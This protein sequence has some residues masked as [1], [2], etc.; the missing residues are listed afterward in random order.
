MERLAELAASIESDPAEVGRQARLIASAARAAEDWAVLSRSQAVVGRAMRMLGEVDSAQSALGEAID[1]AKK[2]GDQELEADAH[3]ALSGALSMAGQWNDAF[4]HLEVAERLGSQELRDSAELQRAVVSWNVGRI[5]DALRLYAGVIPRLRRQSRSLDLA[6]ALA[7]HAG[8]QLSRG[9]V[10]D[11]IGDYEEAEELFRSVGK[12]F[13]A[14]QVHDNLG[15][16]VSHLGD[17][18][19]ALRLFDDA[20]DR[21][22]ELGHDA[23]VPLLARAQALLLGGLSADALTFSQQAARRLHAEGNR[24]AAAKA[25]LAAAEAARLEGDHT[26]ALDIAGRAQQWFAL[27]QSVGWERAAELEVMRSRHELGDLEDSAIDRLEGLAETLSS[28]GNVRGEIQARCLLTIAACERGQLDVAGKQA[29][30]AARATRSS[31]LLQTRL[32]SH[33]ATA[34]YRLASGD[35]I[36]ARRDLRRAFEALESTRQLRGAADAGASIVTQAH[37]IA[38]L[39]IHMATL[40]AQP[41]RALAWMERARAAGRVSRPALP[42]TADTAAGDFARLRV[43]AA[44]LRQAEIAGEPTGDLRRRHAEL[45]RAMRAEWLKS[46]HPDRLVSVRFNLSELKHVV[47]DAQ[48]VSIASAGSSFLAVIADRRRVRSCTL[49]ARA[50]LLDAAQGACG[51]LRGLAATGSAPTVAASRRRNFDA[52]VDVLDSL[53]LVPL[54]LDAQHIV[55]V[56]P[57]EL[58][59]IPWAALPSLRGRSFTLAPSVQWWIEAASSPVVPPTSVLAVAGPRV[60]EAEAEVRGVAAC[61]RRSTLLVGAD[62]SVVNVGGAMA[63]H[64][65]V[66]F[67]A[68]GRFRHDNPLW[69]TLELADG[70][71]S[72]YELERLGQIPS[73]VVLATCES[74]MGG[75]RSGAQLHGLAGTLLAMGAR[76]IV[77][78]IGALPDT[79]ATRQTMIDLHRDLV[80]GTNASKS[81]LSQRLGEFSLTSA[82]LVTLG[83][84]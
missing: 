10:A 30:L 46:G 71:L 29:A 27:D 68:H 80:N 70:P 59:A 58:H 74:G 37:A 3:I 44:D 48:V 2:G 12:E 47:G 45:E 31:Q 69:S 19:R 9:Q 20:S 14:V 35:R 5:D 33:H 55:L 78:A 11:A 15:C 51:A 16:A 28:A 40:E 77:A 36:G 6:R 83:V 50:Q 79:A 61:H 60:A 67:V 32:A 17:L 7:N 21:Y 18:P 23:S 81:L 64:D 57:A 52:A 72:V 25:L 73:T 41:M 42:P 39:A 63:T 75:T 54:R 38:G 8:I 24:A 84:G 26:T 34:T 66:H 62:A 43:V 13:A 53:L 22:A 76:T 4:A 56:M 65:I 1:A 82:G 49:A